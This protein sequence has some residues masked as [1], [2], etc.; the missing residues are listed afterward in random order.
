MF[1]AVGIDSPGLVDV[2]DVTDRSAVISWSRPI[3]EVDGFK[4]SYG[5][6][7]DP[8]AQRD[9]SLPATSTQY[10]L[11]DL[12]PDTEYTVSLTSTRGEDTSEPIYKSFTTGTNALPVFVKLITLMKC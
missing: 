7:S 1:V 4:V 2:G 12:N 11:E 3:A 9:I 5:P 10:S 6:S 8:S